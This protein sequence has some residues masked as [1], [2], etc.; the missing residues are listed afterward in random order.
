MSGKGR[1]SQVRRA[2]QSI[3]SAMDRLDSLKDE[4]PR[5]EYALRRLRDAGLVCNTLS[6]EWRTRPSD[7]PGLAQAFD[8]LIIED[9]GKE[10]RGDDAA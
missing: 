3:V 10:G 1:L 8:A 9:F 6:N 2:R 4:D 5:I 7:G